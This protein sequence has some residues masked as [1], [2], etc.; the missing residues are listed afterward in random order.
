MEVR[1][2]LHSLKLVHLTLSI[3]Q[4]QNEYNIYF[5][6][7]DTF[8]E[9]EHAGYSLICNEECESREGKARVE[10]KVIK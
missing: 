1:S 3:N 10:K 9:K 5:S 8:K 4:V 6:L 2:I 7:G